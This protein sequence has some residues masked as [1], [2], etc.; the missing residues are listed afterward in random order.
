ME[1][2]FADRLILLFL[3]FETIIRFS[4]TFH[5]NS[6]FSAIYNTHD[7]NSENLINNK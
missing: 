5:W 2:V 1:P 7:G 4:Y 6:N 3:H